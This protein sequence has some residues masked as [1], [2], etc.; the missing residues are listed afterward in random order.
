M[1]TRK[2]LTGRN[3]SNSNSSYLL[4]RHNLVP[5]NHRRRCPKP[6]KVALTMTMMT[7]FTIEFSLYYAIQFFES[8]LF[9]ISMPFI[10]VIKTK[11]KGFQGLEANIALQSAHLA[12]FPIPLPFLFLP[13]ESKALLVRDAFST[14]MIKNIPIFSLLS[15]YLI[16]I[17]NIEILSIPRSSA[18]IFM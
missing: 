16:G 5:P 8:W 11:E 18:F 9:F 6:M 3:N 1:P 7:K 17:I 4:Q 15:L 12:A 2:R 14:L 13:Q 10:L